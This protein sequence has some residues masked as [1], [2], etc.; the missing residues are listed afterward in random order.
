MQVKDFVCSQTIDIDQAVAPVEV[1]GWLHFFCSEDCR[2][3]FLADPGRYR[4]HD[5]R[6]FGEHSAAKAKQG[7]RND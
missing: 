4:P 2:T 3:R 5:F 7:A 1:H 6:I